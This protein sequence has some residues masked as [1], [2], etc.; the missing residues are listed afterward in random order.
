MLGVMFVVGMAN[1]AIVIAMGAVMAI[2]KTSSA[3]PRV[4]QLLSLALIVA[5]IATGLGWLH[6]APGHH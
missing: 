1:V 5:G 6:V 4:A 2:M 3:G